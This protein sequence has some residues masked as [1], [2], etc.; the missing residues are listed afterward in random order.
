LDKVQGLAAQGAT[1]I[2]YQ[3]AGDIPRELERFAAAVGAAANR[4]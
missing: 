4:A 3:P 1:E 2:L